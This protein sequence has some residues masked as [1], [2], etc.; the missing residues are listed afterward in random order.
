MLGAEL[1]CEQACGC[2]PTLPHCSS[3][4]G[5]GGD[6]VLVPRSL[7]SFGSPQTAE[8]PCHIPGATTGTSRCVP[9]SR[10]P[11][12]A[13]LQGR[14]LHLCAHAGGQFPCQIS[15]LHHFHMKMPASNACS[16]F[17]EQ[18]RCVR[19]PGTPGVHGAEG[20]WH[21]LS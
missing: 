16:S 19:G 12:R 11:P 4:P 15:P 7:E 20:C 5:S 3:P 10:Q 9:C 1:G 17:L 21:C 14:G 8:Q 13:S 18:P 6:S 2:L